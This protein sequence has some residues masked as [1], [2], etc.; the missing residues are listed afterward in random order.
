MYICIYRYRLIDK[1]MLDTAVTT[2]LKICMQI[3]Y[4]YM[5]YEH[6]RYN[7]IFIYFYSFN[8]FKTKAS[9][10]RLFTLIYYQAMRS[11]LHETLCLAKITM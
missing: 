11:A 3:K 1:Y 2:G 4:R 5:L 9:A 8:S 7:K 10:K 6:S